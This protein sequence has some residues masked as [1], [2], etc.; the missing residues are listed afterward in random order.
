MYAKYQL[1]EHA[2]FGIFLLLCIVMLFTGIGAFTNYWAIIY[3]NSYPSDE[4]GVGLFFYGD[5]S[6]YLTFSAMPSWWQ[7]VTVFMVMAF[8]F[9]ILMLIWIVAAIYQDQNHRN[10]SNHQRR[11]YEY[12]NEYDYERK[13]AMLLNLPTEITVECLLGLNVK[14]LLEI[15]KVNR[16]LHAIAT[17]QKSP[18]RH[19]LKKRHILSLSF[20]FRK[21]NKEN[22]WQGRPNDGDD[23]NCPE[24]EG[25]RNWNEEIWMNVN[26]KVVNDDNWDGFSRWFIIRFWDKCCDKHCANKKVEYAA[27][28]IRYPEQLI[29]GIDD[30]FWPPEDEATDIHIKH[31]NKE[32]AL[33]NLR[34]FIH[35]FSSVYIIGDFN[36]KF[37]GDFSPW[38]ILKPFFADNPSSI[39]CKL[40]VSLT[41]VKF[42]PDQFFDCPIFQ[43]G[44]AGFSYDNVQAIGDPSNRSLYNDVLKKT[45]S[46]IVYDNSGAALDDDTLI[47]LFSDVPYLH[48]NTSD[49]GV[50]L[51]GL[52]RL[53]KVRS[54]SYLVRMVRNIVFYFRITTRVACGSHIRMDFPSF[55]TRN[56]HIIWKISS[57]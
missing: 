38:P 53:T 46:F 47:R 49:L 9:E 12:R 25:V 54:Y 33:Q 15:I 39:R 24:D 4:V 28:D 2:H 23:S 57:L 43:K 30:C 18:L 41:N 45:D 16:R 42:D 29:E 17:H 50:T 52:A 1:H 55:K 35:Y 44:L 5:D 51:H 13:F 40:N 22:P 21:D 19:R 20:N 36:M 26:R 6:P 3:D 10:H 8:A 34:L 37:E 48:L 27:D 11:H 56:T 32:E 7:C 31:H 14:D